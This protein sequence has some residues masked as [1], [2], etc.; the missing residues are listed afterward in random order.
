MTIM[1]H[2]RGTY[3]NEDR[4]QAHPMVATPCHIGGLLV[5]HRAL[6]PAGRGAPAQ[7]AD[8]R[9]AGKRRLLEAG[10]RKGIQMMVARVRQ[11]PCDL[12]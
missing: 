12:P 6:H 2:A 8:V 1:I 11:S 5:A 3:A 10:G 9:D 4:G 7:A